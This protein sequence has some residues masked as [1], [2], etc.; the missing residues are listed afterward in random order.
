MA[1]AW[2]EEIYRP[3]RSHSSVVGEVPNRS[4]SRLISDNCRC[5]SKRTSCLLNKESR[6]G[7]YSWAPGLLHWRDPYSPLLLL[8]YIQRSVCL[9]SS[10]AEVYDR[11]HVARGQ[12]RASNQMQALPLINHHHHHHHH[13]NYYISF[14]TSSLT[15][16]FKDTIFERTRS[17]K[18]KAVFTPSIFFNIGNKVCPGLQLTQ[19][20]TGASFGTTH[21]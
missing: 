17:L 11:Q 3:P 5:P 18:M 19:D 20:A 8:H 21:R 1:L 14:Q 9:V 13:H 4:T 6:V 10:F 15:W 16:F 12:R 7:T 2:F